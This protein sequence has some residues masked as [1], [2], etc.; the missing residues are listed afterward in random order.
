VTLCSQS[1]EATAVSKD[2][3]SIKLTFSFSGC[4]GTQIFS[5]TTENSAIDVDGQIVFSQPAVQLSL[6]EVS[7]AGYD[8]HVSVFGLAEVTAPDQLRVQLGDSPV[9]TLTPTSIVSSV[10]NELTVFAVSIPAVAAAGTVSGTIGL[11]SASADDD[12]LWS[13]TYTTA[14][15]IQNIN[16]ASGYTT[17]KTIVSFNLNNFYVSEK[18]GLSDLK[19]TADGVEV[20]TTSLVVT[21]FGER[22][23]S[24][25]IQMPRSVDAK[26]VAMR[27]IHRAHPEAGSVTFV[28]TYTV[29]PAIMTLD[30][31][32]GTHLGGT[33]VLV[34]IA[35]MYNPAF[36]NASAVEDLLAV[37]TLTISGPSGNTV[38]VTSNITILY[39]KPSTETS[40]AITR[41]SIVTPPATDGPGEVELILAANT[42][43]VYC[44]F[45]YIDTSIAAS[46]LTGIS[47]TS[48]ACTLDSCVAAASGGSV[49]EVT[50]TNF[51]LAQQG[52]VSI[53]YGTVTG[54]AISLDQTG[55][56]TVMQIAFASGCDAGVQR[57][58]ISPSSQSATTVF[59][60]V[61][62][63]ASIAA[64]QVLFSDAT[65]STVQIVFN[66]DVAWSNPC[67]LPSAVFE[68][69]LSKLGL[70]EGFCDANNYYASMAHSAGTTAMVGTSVTLIPGFQP[71]SAI[72]NTTNQTFEIQQ[73]PSQVA[74]VARITGPQEVDLCEST[75]TLKGSGSTGA[76]WRRYSW[77]SPTSTDLNTELQANSAASETVQVDG[78]FLAAG[79]TL[80]VCLVVT[81]VFESASEQVC[82]SISRATLPIPTVQVIGSSTSLLLNTDT[83]NSLEGLATFSACVG[84]QDLQYN[85]IL[86]DSIAS[87]GMDLGSRYLIIPK[88]TLSAGLNVELMLQA[89]AT[90]SPANVGKTIIGLQTTY[91]ELQC[92]I[93]GGSGQRSITSQLV[94]D[95]SASADPASGNVTI[96]WMC[97][98]S[99]GG[100]CRTATGDLVEASA[101]N[102]TTGV[103]SVPADTMVLD[104]YIWTAEVR[105]TEQRWKTCQAT[106]TMVAE[107][108]LTLEMSIPEA[109]NIKD[110]QR[111]SGTWNGGN[112]DFL[113]NVA[114]ETKIE[115]KITV[116]TGSADYDLAFANPAGDMAGFSGLT[117]LASETDNG[118]S[119]RTLTRLLIVTA[120][121]FS[122]GVISEIQC[123]AGA[124]QGYSSLKV[125]GNDAPGS[126]SCTITPDQ[127]NRVT[128]E[129]TVACKE[130]AD[131]MDVQLWND[132][133]LSY[134]YI[135]VD[136]AGLETALSGESQDAELN[137]NVAEAGEYTIVAK[138]S[139][140]LGN[141]KTKTVAVTVLDQTV[142]T[143]DLQNKVDSGMA[144][145]VATG[146]TGNV[147]RECM[148]VGKAL[149]GAS[150]R[151]S[152]TVTTAS[153][154][155]LD[156]SAKGV[157]AS[158][159]DAKVIL[160]SLSDLI[161]TPA[162]NAQLFDAHVA[163]S[164]SILERAVEGMQTLTVPT[165]STDSGNL[166]V[167]LLDDLS[168][169]AVTS[170]SAT[171]I[172]IQSS[173][174]QVR[175]GMGQLTALG[176]SVGQTRSYGSGCIAIMYRELD[177]T[178]PAATYT[179]STGTCGTFTIPD[180]SLPAADASGN[181]LIE[182]GGVSPYITSPPGTPLGNFISTQMFSV[183][184]YNL[185]NTVATVASSSALTGPNQIVIAN[186]VSDARNCLGVSLVS[187]SV[188][189]SSTNVQCSAAGVNNDSPNAVAGKLE[190]KASGTGTFAAVQAL[191]T[192]NP[193]TAAPTAAP[194]PRPTGDDSTITSITYAIAGLSSS[195][196]DSSTTKGQA[197]RN[198]AKE[199]FAST[200]GTEATTVSI[201]QV[202][203]YNRRSGVNVEFIITESGNLDINAVNA[204]MTDAGASGFAQAFIEHALAN[205]YT[206][207]V[208]SVTYL[209]HTINGDCS[210]SNCSGGS[211]GS[212]L[213][214]WGWILIGLAGAIFVA[215]IIVAAVM[216]TRNLKGSA[217]KG[218]ILLS[219]NDRLE[220]DNDLSRLEDV[221]Q[222][223]VRPTQH[224]DIH[225]EEDHQP[226]SSFTPITSATS[227]KTPTHAEWA[228]Q[229][230]ADQSPTNSSAELGDISLSMKP[231][232]LYTDQGQQ[233]GV[234][235]TGNEEISYQRYAVG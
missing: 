187:S 9:Q 136:N 133:T 84:R 145:A 119:T 134:E 27:C 61:D 56:N 225:L 181:Q 208:T 128:E 113:A 98:T 107:T 176:L 57:V 97:A 125:L 168:K 213:P 120:G 26:E 127:G 174:E 105:G 194:T 193:P 2:S 67:P 46:S 91:P 23:L 212:D 12:Q 74:P 211:G 184:F 191:N 214:L 36:S 90:D 123:V 77:T 167:S 143:D 146:D 99:T 151:T 140:S 179:M 72:S 101:S 157:I 47:G 227:P 204:I 196:F 169:A 31:S 71:L 201:G 1:I 76:G 124:S 166:I 92:Q 81:D 62:F 130:F 75:M 35:N 172:S 159:P 30:V 66:N 65:A 218:S 206:V 5:V 7:V 8:V 232:S 235:V 164:I 3:N 50:I 42:R 223:G 139:D 173:S 19:C 111:E 234:S 51:P 95:A 80:Q 121:S 129:F 112:F 103:A 18:I 104:T 135:L 183:T 147:A 197:I 4:V 13:I 226:R 86:P 100:D 54:T 160:Q 182:V 48:P 85:W 161:H 89:W 37:L 43:S 165:I 15:A 109:G 63:E 28:Y 68:N 180:A 203:A 40:S 207:T 53:K 41:L 39:S 79:G 106:Y 199:S 45:L 200:T 10:A 152:E 16:P 155:S 132:N 115:C 158:E 102:S 171:K 64:T 156:T 21:S 29:P 202:Y 22:T 59:I 153:L 110:R 82:H 6:A 138:I 189:W 131:S 87:T 126:G 93:S 142:T 78:A 149:V 221:E 209:S 205:G 118:D 137:F 117:T 215:A 216:W 58:E 185:E 217:P 222:P 55:T 114:D 162:A 170:S 198:S 163:L 88:D 228:S 44:S 33:S 150:R 70:N 195:D 20:D 219:D 141:P 224:E 34:D 220:A 186:D 116:P 11:A 233:P 83:E 188:T 154:Q 122:S 94:L 178:T 25:S 108:V 148:T 38:Y 192:P 96:S 230:A 175:K 24:A 52:D 229:Q 231:D 49:V 73:P 32:E 177:Q 60:Y 210:G 69:A 17:T 144:D 190:L 14:P